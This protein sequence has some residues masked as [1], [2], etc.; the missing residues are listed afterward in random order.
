[1]TDLTH[2]PLWTDAYLADTMHLSYE[3]HGLYLI[4][5]MTLWRSPDCQIPNDMTWIKR[6]MQLSDTQ[7]VVVKNLVKEFLCE[8]KARKYL[9]QKRLKKEYEY[10]IKIKN[11]KRKNAKVRWLKEKEACI[12]NA[13]TPTPTPTPT[14]THN[15]DTNVSIRDKSFLLFWESY[16][17]KRRGAKTVVQRKYNSLLKQGILA[18]DIQDGLD[19]Y[20]NAGFKNS[21]FAKGAHA[22]LNGQCF[23]ITDWMPP[24]DIKEDD[25]NGIN[26][27]IFDSIKSEL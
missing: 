26:R 4:L 12:S 21:K 22:W 11:I 7:M 20:I 23:T 27:A 9:Y 15:I 24:S 6:R 16:P 5:L 14:L 8:C 25:E 1:M 17:R 10:V 3:E 18:G 19:R 2:I 13:P